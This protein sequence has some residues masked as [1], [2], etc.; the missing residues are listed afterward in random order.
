MAFKKVQNKTLQEDVDVLEEEYTETGEEQVVEPVNKPKTLHDIV[1]KTRLFRMIYSGVENRKYFD[2]LYNLGIRDFLI[3][4]HYIAEKKLDMEYYK[5]LGIKFF[6]DSGAY[7]YQGQEKYHDLPKEYWEG[8][9]V[10]YLDWAERHKDV[11]FAIANMDLENL[12][13]FETTKEWN[14]KYFEPFMIR[15]GIPVCFIWHPKDGDE[16][17]EYYTKRY[18]YTGFSW[19]ADSGQD[20]D[21]NFGKKMLDTARKNGSVCHGMGMTRTSLLTKM[22]FY[23]SDSTTWL[24]GLQYGEVNYWTG[25]KMTRLKKEK[26]KGEYLS[27]IVAL[28]C[29]REKLLE[30]DS[31]EMIK[32]N[33]FAFIQAQEYIDLRLKPR[34][35]WLR[36]TSNKRNIND[37]ESMY[38]LF[39]DEDWLREETFED[40]ETYAQNLNINTEIDLDTMATHVYN[41][42]LFCMHREYDM[43]DILME[44]LDDYHEEYINRVVGTDEEKIADLEDYAWKVVSGQDDSLL[45]LGIQEEAKERDKYIEEEEFEEVEVDEKEYLELAENLGIKLLPNSTEGEAPEIDE[46]DKEIFDQ[47]GYAVVRDNKGRFVKGQKLIKKPKNIYS[48]KYP[49][50]ACNTCYAAQTCPQ[51][52][53]GY[54]CAFNK[55]FKRFDCRRTEDILEAMQGMVNLNMERM[56]RV[57]IFEMLDGGMPDSSLTS[58]IDQNM[59]LLM[60]M[61]DVY[62]AQQ[63]V[64][65]QVRTIGADGTIQETTQV[66][67]NAGSGVMEAL[68]KNLLNNNN[69]KENGLDIN[70]VIEVSDVDIKDI[71]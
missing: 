58:M 35:Y 40:V 24:V 37:K 50:L 67:S 32:A 7:T 31:T 70:E 12:F 68:M 59:R 23:T 20:L 21:F 71:K 34:M 61:K 55:M 5:S 6:I 52:K 22:P 48:D 29:N 26:W 51:F 56:Q 14:K 25:K 54:V 19:V 44:L 64:V 33:I 69:N 11:I 8:Q 53:E 43:T 45:L 65:R 49:K 17:W 42:S 3:S 15:T 2:I 47:T 38:D 60:N 39:P 57:A 18:P 46:L 41:I 27:E 9:I 13:D 10:K 30:E 4:Y 28:G 63:E 16:G 1:D 62:E 66:N 36:P